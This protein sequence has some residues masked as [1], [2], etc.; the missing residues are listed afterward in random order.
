MS[1]S[2]ILGVI[3][4]DYFDV[5]EPNQ[6]SASK[7]TGSGNPRTLEQSTEERFPSQ[8]PWPSTHPNLL[9][10]AQPPKLDFRAKLMMTDAE[11]Q[12]MTFD[13]LKKEEEKRRFKKEIAKEDWE[14]QQYETSEYFKAALR[15]KQFFESALVDQTFRQM[16]IK[17]AELQSLRTE[18]FLEERRQMH[19]FNRKISADLLE[20]KESR[21]INLDKSIDRM[22]EVRDL[23]EKK[24][25]SILKLRDN[26]SQNIA[27]TAL[28]AYSMIGYNAPEPPRM[29]SQRDEGR[30]ENQ[31]I[32]RIENLTKSKKAS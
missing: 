1:K 16:M 14:R 24:F 13:I 11:W 12:N 10:F 19:D 4:F 7:G 27:A 26:T 25:E 8:K 3:P 21:R 20:L 6:F 30:H 18:D 31:V 15:R 29:M 32:E 17:A 28:T 22:F 9:N 2:K 5:N 23:A